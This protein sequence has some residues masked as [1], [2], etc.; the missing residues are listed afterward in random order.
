M[1]THGGFIWGT[2]CKLISNTFIFFNKAAILWHSSGQEPCYKLMCHG[3]TTSLALKIYKYVFKFISKCIW[4]IFVWL[5]L[6]KKQPIAIH[7]LQRCYSLT[8]QTLMF[9]LRGGMLIEEHIRGSISC[10][11][12]SRSAINPV[13]VVCLK[14][15]NML[16]APNLISGD[17]KYTLKNVLMGN[18][19]RENCHSMM[20]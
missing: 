12:M 7:N 11:F 3:K 6:L 2:R 14:S 5:G 16:H 1:T 15:V 9:V 10:V 17:T 20:K 4:Y 13:T 18:Q 8:K 19:T